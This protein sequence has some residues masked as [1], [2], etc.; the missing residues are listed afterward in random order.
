VLRKIAAQDGFAGKLL[1]VRADHVLH[2][3]SSPASEAKPSCE[4][5]GG[6]AYL[7]SNAKPSCEGEAV[8]AHQLRLFLTLRYGM[9]PTPHIRKRNAAE[10][11]ISVLKR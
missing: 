8:L 7:R 9:L 4:T 5:A 10:F 1:Q 6:G 11:R 2:C 3:V